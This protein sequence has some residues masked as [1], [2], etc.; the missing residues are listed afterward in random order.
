[1]PDGR[2]IYMSISIDFK[3]TNPLASKL[4][5]GTGGETV[6]GNVYVATLDMVLSGDLSKATLLDS[7]LTKGFTNPPA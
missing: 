1:M 6:R 4:I 7:S 2:E 5:F 3:E